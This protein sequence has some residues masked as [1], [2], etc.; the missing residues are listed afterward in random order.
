MSAADHVTGKMIAG[1]F[2]GGVQTIK[3][4]SKG[5]SKVSVFKQTDITFDPD[6]VDAISI[7]DANLD[8]YSQSYIGRR[9]VSENTGIICSREKRRGSHSG[10]IQQSPSTCQAVKRD[11]IKCFS[12][13]ELDGQNS[14]RLYTTEL[15][16]TELKNQKAI[17]KAS[18]SLEIENIGNEGFNNTVGELDTPQWGVLR[19]NKSKKSPRKSRFA[20][21]ELKIK[22]EKTVS[23]QKIDYNS[24]YRSKSSRKT[25]EA[26]DYK[27]GS[28]A[29][30][31]SEKCPEISSSPGSEKTLDDYS[32][33]TKLKKFGFH[34]TAKVGIE[35]SHYDRR[36][37]GCLLLIAGILFCVEILSNQHCSLSS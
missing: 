24:E 18:I 36:L 21:V 25:D 19:V 23:K 35:V 31:N 32:P 7:V 1:S 6:I 2:H 14:V 16:L 34:K 10:L 12:F 27:Q 30:V 29:V 28:S 33:C 15:S 22:S 37:I 17:I 5:G 11:L 13:C 9:K 4:E 8:E 26:E 20:Q 3:T